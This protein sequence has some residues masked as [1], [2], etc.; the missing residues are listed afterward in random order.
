MFVLLFVVT[1]AGLQI[2][3]MILGWMLAAVYIGARIVGIDT[4]P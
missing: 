2:Q 3:Q 4:R 1:G